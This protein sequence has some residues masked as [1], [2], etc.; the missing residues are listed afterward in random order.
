MIKHINIDAI[1]C[2]V[3]IIFVMNGWGGGS[4]GYFEDEKMG[5]EEELNLLPLIP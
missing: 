4:H 1:K 5:F 3:G 2:V